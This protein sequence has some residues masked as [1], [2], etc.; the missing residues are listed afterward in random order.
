MNRTFPS[1]KDRIIL[2]AVEIIN[3]SGI[4]GISTKELA[5]RQ[6]ITESLLYRYFKSKDDIIVAVIEY[7]SCFDNV[8]MNTI[9][10]SD[11]SYRERITEF[12]CMF[13]EYYENY[14]AITSILHY[15]HQLLNDKNT[16]DLVKDIFTKRD[17]FLYELI[18]SGQEIGEIS[19]FF[20][21]Y[22]LVDIIWGITKNLTLKWSID[23]YSFPLKERTISI[24]NKI[25][26]KCT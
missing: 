16:S 13:A 11:L 2:T 22:E 17:I 9:L 14:P 25:F 3:D 4:Q 23:G 8:I 5:K 10:K 12:I 26:D 7:Y 6:D 20:T 21:P 24:L 1:R 19:Q 15:Y 18:K